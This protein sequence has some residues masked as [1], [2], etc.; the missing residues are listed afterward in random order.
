[1]YGKYYKTNTHGKQKRGGDFRELDF[2]SLRSPHSETLKKQNKKT[3]KEKSGSK[4][5]NPAGIFY[6]VSTVVLKLA[7]A[8]TGFLRV[9]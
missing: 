7:G 9:R 3:A 5:V 6:L 4:S 8:V 1:M 2:W